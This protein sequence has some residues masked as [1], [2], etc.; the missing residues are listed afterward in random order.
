[1]RIFAGKVVN[2]HIE[3]PPDE[4]QEGEVVAVVA[5]D[6]DGPVVLTPEEDQRI[7]EAIEAIAR[8]DYVDGDEFIRQLKQRH[9]G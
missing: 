7:T 2:G 6:E 8:G 5:S 9:A 3:V 1:M 4:F